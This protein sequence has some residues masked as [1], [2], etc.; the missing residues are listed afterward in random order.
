[1]RW[2]Q[3]PRLVKPRGLRL[4]FRWKTCARFMTLPG[5]FEDYVAGLD[6]KNRHELRRK[7]RRAAR[8]RSRWYIV[9]AQHDLSAS[10][11]CSCS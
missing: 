5:P 10:W 6:K 3:L 7:M 1:M 8:K 11:S 2:L 9:G 4:M